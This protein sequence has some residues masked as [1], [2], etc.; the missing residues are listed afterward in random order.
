MFPVVDD[1]QL[2]GFVT[3]KQLRDLDSDEWDRHTI[4]ELTTQD[5]PENT[6]SSDT[7]MMDA[8]NR[9]NR[10][11]HSRLLLVDDGRLSGVIALKDIMG[12]LSTHMD[13]EDLE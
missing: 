8:M 11:D 2:K 4:A 12:Y 5:S 7:D 10:S 1:G 3:S 13:I 6:V 9:M